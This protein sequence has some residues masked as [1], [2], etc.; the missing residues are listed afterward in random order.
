MPA[1]KSGADATTAARDAR[2]LSTLLEMS[3]ALSGTLNLKAAMQRV[4]A[5]LIRHHSVVRGMVTCLRDGELQVEAAEGFEDRARALRFKVGEGITGKVV[6]SGRP[7][8]VPRVSREPAFL[9]LAPRR[10][11]HPKQE[12]SFICVPIMLNR[13]AVGALGVD[14]RFKPERDYDS[15]VKFFGVVS[16]MI[17]QALNV[18]R[19]VEEERRRLTDENTHLRQELRER[20]DFSNIIGTSGPTRQMYEQVAQVA[21]TNTT[22]LIR[23]ESGT[24][25]ELIAHAI[26]YNSLRAKKPFVKVSCAA[27]PETLIESELF[28][29][30]K[31]A[32]TG[33]TT[34]KKGRFEMAE[35]GT[36]FLD[37]IGDINPGTQVKLLRVLQEREFERLG[38]TETVKV[39]VRLIAATNKDMEKALAD[40]TF[41]EDLYYRLNVFTIFVPPLRERKADLL[42]LADHFL[43]KFSREHGKVIKRIST[44]AIDMLMAYHWPGNVREMENALERAVLV[45]DAAVIHGHHLP[46]SLQTADSSGTVTRVALKDAVAGYERDLILDALKTTRGNRAKAARLLDTT[47]RILNYKVR[48]YGI[49]VR[50]F[51]TPEVGRRGPSDAAES[52][53]DIPV[54]ASR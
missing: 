51:K 7:I 14:L 29:Y 54:A 36:L 12:L 31:G 53:R 3:Q 23:G 20:Y 11:D 35:G 18:Q 4:L 32:F 49:D 48:G 52:P 39:N 30:E 41:R 8:V 15:S 5:T 24:G 44:P 26:H 28:G 16:S 9:N 42:L 13:S 46:P 43:E 25:K 37:E 17:A 19:M 38:G 6:E 40:A 45:C 10:P 21:Q 50:R 27:L 34:R 33:A 22:V 2:R 1:A 47:E